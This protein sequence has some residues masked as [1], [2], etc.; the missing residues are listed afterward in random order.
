MDSMGK[1]PGP[2]PGAGMQGGWVQK[3]PGIYRDSLV[4][5]AA[6]D[7]KGPWTERK[8]RKGQRKAVH[9]VKGSSVKGRQKQDPG[10]SWE[11]S[12]RGPTA[13]S[14]ANSKR[15]AMRTSGVWQAS[16]LPLCDA[17]EAGCLVVV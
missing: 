10:G 8:S 1:G 13:G 15:T 11:C 4:G 16:K 14:F 17:G 5:K 3:G 7:R 2:K 12:T 6:G 9:A